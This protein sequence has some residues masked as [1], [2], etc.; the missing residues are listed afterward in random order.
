V[1]FGIGDFYDIVDSDIFAP[2]IKRKRFVE[3]S[4]A[5]VVT[6]AHHS[7]TLCVL[8]LSCYFHPSN[9]TALG[10]GKGKVFLLQA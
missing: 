8:F 1:K 10:K 3:F 2:A 6:P 7:V 9:I 5:T 4:L